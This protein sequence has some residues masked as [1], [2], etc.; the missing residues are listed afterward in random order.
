MS[1]GPLATLNL[2]QLPLYHNCIQGK[3]KKR[4]FITKG[5]RADRFLNLIHS[6]VCG[7]FS[8]HA[9][10]GYEYFITFTDD[11]SRYGYV[12]LMKKKF[13]A[14]DKFKEFKAELEKQLGRHITLRYVRGGKY[15]SIEFVS[16]SRRMRF[17]LSLVL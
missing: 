5:V 6:N 11:L 17:Y 15:M 12:Y 2:E 16:S 4:S 13:E 10:G 9:R 1:C 14:L 7:R 8:V 3:M